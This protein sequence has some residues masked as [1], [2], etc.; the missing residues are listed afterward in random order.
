MIVLNGMAGLSL[1]AGAARHGE[2]VFRTD[3]I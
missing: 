1:L 2:Q 3:R